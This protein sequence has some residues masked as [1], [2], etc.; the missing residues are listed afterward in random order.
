MLD[1]NPSL[2]NAD[3]TFGTLTNPAS[4]GPGTF[5]KRLEGSA[6]DI[7]PGSVT[8]THRTG[9]PLLECW[10]VTVA[11]HPECTTQEATGH[12]WVFVD[13]ALAATPTP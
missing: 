1:K 6:T 10:E 9:E 12:G 11:G 8:V 4:W 3:A 13:D 5:E 7:P 2:S